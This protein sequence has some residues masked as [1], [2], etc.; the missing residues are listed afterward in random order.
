MQFENRTNTKIAGLTAKVAQ[1]TLR[2]SSSMITI[3]VLTMSILPGTF[4]SVRSF[5]S[6]IL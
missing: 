6:V 1:Q 4:I 5:P 2:D 3:A